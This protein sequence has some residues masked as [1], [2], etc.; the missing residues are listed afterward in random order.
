MRDLVRLLRRHMTVA[1]FILLLALLAGSLVAIPLAGEKFS[2]SSE[3]VVTLDGRPVYVLSLAQ[4]AR[5]TLDAPLGPV[6][7]EVR[8]GKVR[9]VESSCPDKFCVASRPVTPL[10]GVIV[11]AP[12]RLVIHVHRHHVGDLD[13]VTQ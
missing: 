4:N 8:E 11:C 13:C 9:V 1:D 7:I 6:V 12:N 2:P 3:A 5:V 10:G